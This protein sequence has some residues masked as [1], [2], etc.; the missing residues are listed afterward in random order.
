MACGKPIANLADHMRRTLLAF[1]QVV[2]SAERKPFQAHCPTCSA[3]RDISLAGDVAHCASCGAELRMSAA[4]LNAF[5]Q[6]MAQ[7]EREGKKEDE[8]DR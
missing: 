3:R 4:F 2:R 8:G 1:G 7:L 6:H 5:R